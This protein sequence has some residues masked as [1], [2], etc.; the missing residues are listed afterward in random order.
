M[1]WSSWLKQLG[2]Y[3]VVMLLQVFLFNQLQ[4]FGVCHPYV[5]ILCLLMLP[6]TL[7]PSADLVIGAGAGLM[8]DIFSNS[9]GIHMASCVLIMYIR[10]YLLG[11]LVNDRDRLNEQVSLHAIGF[12]AMLQY[13]VILVFIH[14]LTVFAL[15]AWSWRHF[16]FVLLETFVSGL[17]TVLVILGYNA[18]RNK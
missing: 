1:D 11:L 12:V 5:Y 15:A 13:V 9:L 3:V 7:H 10:R 8:M 17:L 18:L 2:R 4:L 16:G 14:H 6:I